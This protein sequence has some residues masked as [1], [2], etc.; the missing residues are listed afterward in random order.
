MLIGLAKA[1]AKDVMYVI[2]VFHSIPGFFASV[3]GL[4]KASP[5]S[6]LG[7]MEALQGCKCITSGPTL[8]PLI[9][10]SSR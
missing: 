8:S 5:S 7:L 3:I 9:S 1:L 2:R 4:G 6:R 10:C